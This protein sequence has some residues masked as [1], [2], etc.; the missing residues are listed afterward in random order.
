MKQKMKTYT[1]DAIDVTFDVA[2]CIHARECI[3][4]LA[5]KAVDFRTED[6]A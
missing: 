2:R 3:T 5:T 6:P 4:H 1:S